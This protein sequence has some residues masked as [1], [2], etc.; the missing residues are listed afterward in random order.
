MIN[1]H[2]GARQVWKFILIN[3]FV[4]INAKKHSVGIWH[5]VSRSHFERN[6][7]AFLYSGSTWKDCLLWR[8]MRS[9]K[10]PHLL[11]SFLVLTLLIT[12]VKSPAYLETGHYGG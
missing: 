2:A 7:Q 9:S 5:S 12:T 3:S 6:H 8:I 10:T 1:F 11:L 4:L